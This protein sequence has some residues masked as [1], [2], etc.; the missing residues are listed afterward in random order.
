MKSISTEDR[1][2]LMKKESVDY[3]SFLLILAIL[4][5][6]INPILS[7]NP[8]IQDQDPSTYAI[9]PVLMLPVFALFI[10]KKRV[11]RELS[12]R[13]ILTGIV[14]F[15]AFLLVLL[16]AEYLVSFNF[17]SFRVDMLILPLGMAAVVT[18]LFGLKNVE[19]FKA[20]MLYSI[21]ASPILL[22]PI[23]GFNDSFAQLNTITVYSL[24]HPFVS[25]AVYVP[26]FSIRTS[27][28]TIG[29]GSACAGIAVFIALM[30]FLI[31][32]AFFYE[33]ESAGKIYWVV[34]GLL[35][36]LFLN[37]LRMTGIAGVWLVYGPTTTVSFVHL[38]V[39]IFLFYLA[40]IVML[41]VA[42]RFGLRF[43][44]WKVGDAI[45]RASKARKNTLANASYAV[46]LAMALVYYLISTNYQTYTNIS[47]VVLNKHVQFNASNQGL[48]GL[49]SNIS[50]APGWSSTALAYTNGSYGVV[51]LY[52]RSFGASKN[53]VIMVLGS[54]SSQTIK[55]ILANSILMGRYT[56]VNNLGLQTN[57]YDVVSKNS[58]FFVGRE[59]LPYTFSN[60]SSTVIDIYILIP[61]ISQYP[62]LDCPTKYS[63]FYS[64]I[65]SMASLSTLQL[66]NQTAFSQIRTAYCIK[67]EFV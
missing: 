6:V 35:L 12:A 2:V 60:G 63:G 21:L 34:S 50:G 40:V 46:A 9:V 41:L 59:L 56:F 19:K 31:P 25:S 15:A 55:S 20:L 49:F 22:M 58:T 51:S 67:S 17:V 44:K 43:P 8:Y 32:V 3:S 16:F 14:L 18:V 29:I 28:Y 62:N 61:K 5:M 53:P 4:I 52:N 10:S 26:P 65:F 13:S 33:G 54:P 39:G 37:L 38:F 64:A 57:F 1:V 23:V 47:P 48:N 7:T 30:M 36:L 42:P 24:I 45:G 11:E 27:L 66:S